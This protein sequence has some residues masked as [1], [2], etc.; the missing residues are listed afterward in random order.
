MKRRNKLILIGASTGGPGHLERI[1]KK[2]PSNLNSK[3][4]IAQHMDSSLFDSF[5]K[6]LDSICDLSIL[7]STGTFPIDLSDVIICSDTCTLEQKDGSFQLVSSEQ[8][9][10][11]YNPSIDVL[12]ESAANFTKDFDILCILLTGIGNDGAQGM[13][14]LKKSGTETIAESEKSAI[15]YGMP[16]SAFEL[17]A[18]NKVLNLDEIIEEIIRFDQND[19][20][21]Y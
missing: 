12:F 4:I 9:N 21:Q 8:K 11:I 1:L 17:G 5:T 6:R 15:V 2:L 16:R 18:A 3:V 19:V 20:C 13:L 7:K 10:H 14:T